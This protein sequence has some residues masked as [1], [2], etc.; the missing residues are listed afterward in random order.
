MSRGV[1][2]LKYF[3]ISVLIILLTAG[4]G[5][6]SGLKNTN[7]NFTTSI[8]HESL[9]A[10]V[11]VYRDDH[12]IPTIIGENIEDVLF[13]QG[14]EYARDRA[15]QLEFTKAV[16]NGNLMSLFGDDL[17]ESDVFL[18]TI[19]LKRSAEQILPI[20][21]STLLEYIEAYVTG[22]NHYV[23]THQNNPP[24]ELAILGKT[25][26]TWTITDVLAVQG[27][28]AYDLA[29]G[30][31]NEEL[32]VLKM[33]QVLGVDDFI[34]LY[35]IKNP[36]IINYLQNTTLDISALSTSF[37]N[38]LRHI[39]LENGLDFGTGSNNFVIHGNKTSTGN[40]I[41][42]N[43]P[44]LGLTTPGIWWKVNLIATADNFHVEGFALPGTP[45]V[46][47]GHNDKVA[48]GVTNT[49][50]DA[51][52]LYYLNRNTT[53][54][55]VNDTWKEIDIITEEYIFANGT[56]ISKDILLTDFGFLMNMSRYD[57]RSEY[58]LQWVLNQ[59][60]QRDQILNALYGV[61]TA[62]NVNDIVDA[63][64]YWAVPGQNIVFASVDGDIGYQYTGIVPIRKSGFG[65]FPKNGSTGEYGWN[66][67]EAYDKQLTVI[68]PA[69]GFW[70]TANQRI[71]DRFTIH[72]S[73]DYA[74]GYR[75]RRANQVLANATNFDADPNRFS[76]ADIRKLQTD[77]Y[78]TAADD[79]LTSYKTVISTSTSETISADL[80]SE[81]QVELINWN[82]HMDREEIGA[83][84]FQVYRLFFVY[85]TFK[86]DLGD[87][88]DQF[89]EKGMIVVGNWAVTDPNNAFFDNQETDTVETANEIAT[90]AFE[91]AVAYLLDTYGENIEDW[92]YGEMHQA[93]FEHRMGGTLPFLNTGPLPA[94]GSD[95]TLNAGG[96]PGWNSETSIRFAQTH[97]PSMRL[98]AEVEPSWSDVK[99]LVPVGISGN[100]LS[101][102]YN[103]FFE[104]W[105]EG[106]YFEWHYNQSYV[107]QNIPVM[108]T[109]VRDE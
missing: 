25:L 44:H 60:Y 94:V 28:M 7:D 74:V 109:Y 90:I 95:F 87:A 26:T 66:G 107:E 89:V 55:L 86:D 38:P 71:D 93:T 49:N 80:Y 83:T 33:L 9:S 19:G 91:K 69:Q 34:E 68:N 31:V 36:A 85:E 5:V 81:A 11:K 51:V 98:V 2:I 17:Y 52:D 102:H 48:W 8:S 1:T 3:G 99:G 76:T 84:I 59:G 42:A 50:T 43:D 88:I 14:Y 22:V 23:N 57:T 70:A 30:H 65:L 72:I 46:T 37:E 62:E 63:L 54:Y 64:E 32:D 100:I 79:L 75:G 97:G 39:L 92:A 47:I 67:T 45:F 78:N 13:A 106:E 56:S 105:L 103:D 35:P 40:P 41:L 21:D 24:V 53:H 61:N 58:A 27:V 4:L 18:R 104:A 108:A 16:A 29:W 77:T 6:L 10:E 82:Y 15:F 73:E 101:D 96:S 12:G 20:L